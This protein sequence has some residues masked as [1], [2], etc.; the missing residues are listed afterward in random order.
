MPFFVSQSQID[1]L[2]REVDRLANENSRLMNDLLRARLDASTAQ[3]QLDCERMTRAGALMDHQ[4]PEPRRVSSQAGLD[5]ILGGLAATNSPFGPPSGGVEIKVIEVIPHTRPDC[6]DPEKCPVH[7]EG[8]PW[9]HDFDF[10]EREAPVPDGEAA[11]S[12]DNDPTSS[13]EEARDTDTYDGFRD[14]DPTAI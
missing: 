13:D 1:Y 8:S 3:T 11:G 6:N 7:Y 10:L 14:L 9:S 12:G 2:L 4:D 5:S